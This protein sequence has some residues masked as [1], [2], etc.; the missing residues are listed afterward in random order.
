M[1]SEQIQ[2][3]EQTRAEP[4]IVEVQQEARQSETAISGGKAPGGATVTAASQAGG[5]Q[6]R[7]RSFWRSAAFPAWVALGLIAASV[8]VSLLELIANLFGRMRLSTWPGLAAIGFYLLLTVVQP[9]LFAWPRRRVFY[10][11]AIFLLTSVMASFL[12]LALR[13]VWY[14]AV[15]GIVAHARVAFKKRAALL[16]EAAVAAG[17]LLGMILSGGAILGTLGLLPLHYQ[18]RTLLDIA[19]KDGLSP[20]KAGVALEFAVWLVG[21]VFVHAFTGLGMQERAARLRSDTLVSELTEAQAQL[22]AY[23][24]RAEELATMRERERVARE[25][26]DTLAQGLA[27]IQMH[28]ETGTRVF[29]EQPDLSYRHMQRASSLAREY[30]RETRTSILQLRADALDGQPLPAALSALAASWQPCETEA[31][32]T[33]VVDVGAVFHLDGIGADDA[34]W[35]S[36]ALSLE[37]ACYRVAQEA[38]TNARKHGHARRVAIELSI[39]SGELCLTVTDDGSGFDPGRA[40]DCTT[41]GGF[42]LTG[43]RERVKLLNGRL[44]VISAPGAGTQIAAMLPLAETT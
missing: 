30:L 39:E 40:P 31:D 27:A 17:V 22:R 9:R 35:R 32:H 7:L 8:G 38:L 21:L 23:A 11:A 20:D 42:G 44:E 15:Y 26:H 25:I 2:S 12:P 6:E 10:L 4:R 36:L 24:L 19:A 28:L 41:S 29:H 18:P 43:M 1:L 33:R 5:W 14:I 13:A 37:L 3:L 34:L 16:V